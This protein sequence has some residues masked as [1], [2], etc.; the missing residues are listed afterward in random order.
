MQVDIYSK[1]SLQI[2]PKQCASSESCFPL[3]CSQIFTT[4]RQYMRYMYFPVLYAKQQTSVW[5]QGAKQVVHWSASLFLG[6]GTPEATTFFFKLAVSERI[7]FVKSCVASLAVNLAFSRPEVQ[8]CFL[9]LI[10]LRTWLALAGGNL[11][12]WSGIT[13]VSWSSASI[14]DF[15]LASA[16]R[17]R[18]PGSR[19]GCM[20]LLQLARTCG[21][22]EHFFDLLTN[23]IKSTYIYSTCSKYTN[24]NIAHSIQPY[25]TYIVPCRVS[26]PLPEMVP[27]VQYP[28]WW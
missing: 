3:S 23:K 6:F 27:L 17:T 12:K 14:A 20:V 18:W 28:Y 22:K 1:S 26:T 7:N 15:K 10:V 13:K 5:P 11:E 4:N 21:R 8:P 2:S 25:C 9:D 16:L 19:F 24:L